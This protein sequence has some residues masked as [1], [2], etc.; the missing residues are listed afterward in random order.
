MK[1]LYVVMMKTVSI[2]GTF[3]NKDRQVRILSIPR[4]VE[5]Q[6]RDRR[7]GEY[8]RREPRRVSWNFNLIV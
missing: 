4:T 2:N 6:S 5:Q 7:K 8:L 1:R 3:I